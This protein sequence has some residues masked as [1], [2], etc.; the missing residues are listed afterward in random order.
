MV[1]LLLL[2]LLPVAHHVVDRRGV[3]RAED[4]RVAAH[5]LV[6]DAPFDVAEAERADLLGEHD[7]EDHLVEQVPELVDE[8]GVRR[9]VGVGAAGR[10]GGE[11]FDRLDDL[12]GLLE[13]V[14]GERVVGLLR[15]PWAAARAAQRPGELEEPGQLEARR[16]ARQGDGRAS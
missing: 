10:R 3:D 6:V 9:V 4:V 13:Q 14:A 11:G 16:R 12:V 2:D 15:V 7:V 8:R 1:L 5:E